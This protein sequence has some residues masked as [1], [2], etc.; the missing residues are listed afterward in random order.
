MFCVIEICK[1]ILILT[2]DCS[3]L[4][5]KCV[6]GFKAV[7]ALTYTGC[8]EMMSKHM[9]YFKRN[10]VSSGCEKINL[11]SIPSYQYIFLIKN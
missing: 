6:L 4:F 1:I 2:V 11:R 10:D 8:P 9:V 3:T 7:L 5:K